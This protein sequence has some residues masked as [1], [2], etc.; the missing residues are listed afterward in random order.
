MVPGSDA[1]GSLSALPS[2]LKQGVGQTC[3]R[4]QRPLKCEK[5]INRLHKSAPGQACLAGR[6]GA[7]GPARGLTGSLS[8]LLPLSCAPPEEPSGKAVRTYYAQSTFA[9]VI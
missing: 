8:C 9:L 6:R 5:K 4:L 2:C 7:G 3:V 1:F